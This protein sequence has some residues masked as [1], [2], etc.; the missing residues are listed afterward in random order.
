M[1]I[2]YREALQSDAE[3][4]LEHLHAVGGETDNLSFGRDDFNISPEKESRFIERFKRSENDL[5]L[6]AECDGIIVGNAIVEREKIKR[7][8]HRAELSIT[9]LRDFWGRGIGSKLMS[10]MLDFCKE[11]GASVITLYV[12]ADNERAI[13]LYKK[14]GFSEVGVFKNYFNIDEQLFDGLFMQKII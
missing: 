2:I 9:V 10:M 12:R 8:S 3:A 1:N 14:F 6:V 4:L 11:S 7:F 5:M 13:S